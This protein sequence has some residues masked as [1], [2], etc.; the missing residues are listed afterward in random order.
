MSSMSNMARDTVKDAKDAVKESAKAAS[1]ASGDIKDDLEALR[2][3]VAKL[4]QQIADILAAKGGK[5]WKRA[6]KNIDGVI[7][8]VEDKGMEAVDAVREASDHVVDAIDESIQTRPYT[9][10]AI[11]FG[12]GFL[13]GVTRR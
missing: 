10:L 11:A 9:T 12:L 7:S 6:K 8:D 3:D 13:F 5:A 4:T 1:A 2:D